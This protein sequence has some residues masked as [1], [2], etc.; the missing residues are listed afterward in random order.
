MMKSSVCVDA[1]L[2]VRSL[3]PVPFAQEAEARLTIW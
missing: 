3:T 2:I 1:N